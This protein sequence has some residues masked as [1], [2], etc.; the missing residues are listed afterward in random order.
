[1]TTANL[2]QNTQQKWSELL[3]QAVTQPG[4]ILKAYSAFWGYS[5]GN[6]IAALVQCQVRK[7]EPGPIDT[8]KGWQEKGRSVRQGQKAIWL[9]MPLTRKK[10]NEETGE[11]EEFITCFVW[12]PRW[13]V[14]AQTE[15]EPVP[16]PETP[17][18][19]PERRRETEGDHNEP[20]QQNQEQVSEFQQSASDGQNQEDCR[21]IPRGSV[22]NC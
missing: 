17:N 9:C 1:M 10:T 4:L 3:A 18:W 7:I 2:D 5:L 13:F 21:H 15:G 14:L 20:A 12:K 6:R 11:K 19:N 16:M 22:A 8:F